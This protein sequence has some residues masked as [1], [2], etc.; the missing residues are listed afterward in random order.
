MTCVGDFA[1]LA[2][3]VLN[4]AFESDGSGD[5]NPCLG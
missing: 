5:V 1:I 2:P 4:V 3:P